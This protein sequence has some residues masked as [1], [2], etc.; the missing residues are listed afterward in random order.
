M[1][2]DVS[3]FILFYCIFDVHT[4]E[5]RVWISPRYTE[6]WPSTQQK[7]KNKHQ[8]MHHIDLRKDLQDLNTIKS[9]NKWWYV[10]V[11]SLIWLF[12][13]T[14]ARYR[15]YEHI[16]KLDKWYRKGEAIMKCYMMPLLFEMNEKKCQKFVFSYINSHKSVGI[17]FTI[18]I[19]LIKIFFE[20]VAWW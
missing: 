13:L 8:L 6:Y 15:H 16:C 3:N 10:C 19:Y 9:I 11:R 2:A 18:C 20:L 12:T 14:S 5:I 17:P 4:H 7:T 1:I